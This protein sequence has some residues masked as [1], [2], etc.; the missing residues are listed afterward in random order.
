MRNF[1]T[2]LK[3]LLGHAPLQVGEVLEVADGA[4]KVQ[5]PGGAIVS[6]RGSAD[7]GSQVYVRGGV[8]EGIAPNLPLHTID[9]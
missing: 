3:D 8:V 6:A 2:Q 4:V 1:L 9:I 5:L 7:V